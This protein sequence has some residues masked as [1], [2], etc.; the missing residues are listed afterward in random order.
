MEKKPSVDKLEKHLKMKR[1]E[2]IFALSLQHYTAAQVGRMFNID[3]S[4][5]LRIIRTKPRDWRPKW[6]KVK[7]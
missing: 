3:R 4:T 6:E 7:E 2:L 5:A 1:N